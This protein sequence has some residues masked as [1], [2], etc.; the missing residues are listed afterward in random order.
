MPFVRLTHNAVA[1]FHRALCPGNS[2]NWAYRQLRRECEAA[3]HSDKPPVWLYGPHPGN[4]G[5]LLLG[6][7]NVALALRRGRA[8]TCLVNPQHRLG[9]C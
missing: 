8:V 9:A 2:L 6:S 5:Y 4:D 7:G 3:Q 1:G